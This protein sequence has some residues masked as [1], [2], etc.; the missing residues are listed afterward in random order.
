MKRRASANLLTLWLAVLPGALPAQAGLVKV[1]EYAGDHLF[2][3]ANPWEIESLDSGA[4]AG[5]RRTGVELWV[6]DAPE[7]GLVPVCRFYSVAFAPRSA[8]FYT[9]DAVECEAVKANPHWI[10]EGVAFYV[11]PP[12][13]VSGNWACPSGYREVQR[14]YNGGNGGAP[15]HILHPYRGDWDYWDGRPPMGWTVEGFDDWG[16]AFCTAF[17]GDGWGDLRRMREGRE[18]FFSNS[19]WDLSVAVE[20]TGEIELRLTFLNAGGGRAIGRLGN[21]DPSVEAPPVWFWYFPDDY[22]FVEG[23]GYPGPS[24]ALAAGKTRLESI[25]L[26]Y[27]GSDRVEGGACLARR[28][29]EP[30]E[31]S[32]VWSC[33]AVVG[34]R[35]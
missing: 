14:W 23:A 26:H 9:A 25:Y 34:Y 27:V 19:V 11:K 4:I 18:A 33:H 10:D 12:E 24:I 1:I 30:P 13:K 7:P 20:G 29:S 17:T 28:P 5:W 8:H 6:H 31:A 16:V 2:L 22:R 21:L 3:T 35:Q 32:L 15:Q